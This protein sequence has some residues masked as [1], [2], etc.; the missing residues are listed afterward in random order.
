MLEDP[1][2]IEVHLLYDDK[3]HLMK[4]VFN[5][6]TEL[7]LA[8]VLEKLINWSVTF[9]LPN[10]ERLHIQA[11]NSSQNFISSLF[12]RDDKTGPSFNDSV[13]D[14]LCI[15]QCGTTSTCFPCSEEH[16][17]HFEV[18]CCHDGYHIPRPESPPPERERCLIDY[19]R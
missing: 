14:I 3:I 11:L 16:N 17:R 7:T 10:H 9:C 2:R 5:L 1:Y 12:I 13:T 8:V 18:I 19:P 6:L 4:F 15:N